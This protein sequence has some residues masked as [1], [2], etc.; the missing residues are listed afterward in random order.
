MAP[1][2]DI[3]DHSMTALLFITPPN[4]SDNKKGSNKIRKSWLNR[5][6]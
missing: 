6:A 5:K 3:S 1:R 2:G 4:V